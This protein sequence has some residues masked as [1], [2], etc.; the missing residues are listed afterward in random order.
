L[1]AVFFFA[2]LVKLGFDVVQWTFSP[3]AG[4][5]LLA[6]LIIWAVGLLSD[7]ISRFLSGIDE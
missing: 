5:F 7:Q 1:G 3:S 2:G 6:A 4:I